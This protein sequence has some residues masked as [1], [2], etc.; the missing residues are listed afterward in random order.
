[1]YCRV[2][3]CDFDGTGAAGG[4]LAPE[5]AEALGL[6]RRRGIVT[7]LVTGR[8]LDDLKMANVDLGVF[9]A[10]VGENGALVWLPD[11]QRTIQM[12]KPPPGHFLGELRARGVPLQAGAVVVGTWDRHTGEVLD[13]IR[14]AGVDSQLVFN[15][16]ALMLLPS[17]INKATGVERAL[18][19]LGRS[20]RNMIAFGDAENDLPLLALAEV[21]VA[22][23]GSVPS[24]AAAA[25]VQLSQGGPEG[26]AIYLRHLLERDGVVPTP[27]R[28]HVV[29]GHD[30]GGTPATLPASG[31]NVMITGDPRAG[32]SWLA[33]LAA[34]R[35]IEE[36]YR[37][38]VIDPEGDYKPLGER[39]QIVCLG[40]TLALP[41]PE[42]LPDVLA[43][44]PLSVILD[45]ALLPQHAKLRYVDEA[46]GALEA[47]R[48]VTGIPHW[49]IVDEAHY[50]FHED[51]PCCRHFESRTGN[52]VFVTYRPSL[53][54][55]PVFASAGA[56]VVTRTE[57][58]DE[59]YFINSLLQA[60]GPKDLVPSD[61]LASLGLPAAGLLV[62]EDGGSRWQ[63]FQP[64]ERASPHTRHH[65]KYADGRLPDDKAFRFLH[66]DGAGPALAHNMAEFR[67]A[68]RALPLASLEHHLRSGDFSRWAREV[69]GDAELAGGLAKI[70]HTAALGGMPRRAEII[71]HIEDRYMI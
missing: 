30:A 12:G 65:R 11:Q 51:A 22:A 38:C 55:P 48:R 20:A 37:V 23:R 35:L 25:D 4:S 6:A 40:E 45:L 32:K 71:R 36:G 42:R 15:R 57:I 16:S 9:D 14:R 33:G 26:V 13:L 24:L 34:E 10:V 41:P 2:L 18:A 49:I 43:T 27:P 52:Y 64:A 31:L 50:F 39:P 8:V 54:A 68:I 3:A 53:V 59:R 28:R 58:E 29:L 5:V 70:E 17:G 63:V 21:G 46:L 47:A 7:M 19:E 1:M 69:L 44:M 66:A 62:E 56:F 67:D 61:A 60:R